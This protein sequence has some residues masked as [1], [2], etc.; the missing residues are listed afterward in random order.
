MTFSD[1]GLSIKN[2]ELDNFRNYEK[3][4]SGELS[5]FNIFIGKNGV[6]KTNIIESIQLLTSLES[7]RN[8]KWNEVI[9]WGQEEANVYSKFESDQRKLDVRLQI[10]NNKRKYFLNQ[11]PKKKQDLRGLLPAVLFSPDDMKLI[12]GYSDSRR[13]ALDSIG[14][15]ISGTYYDLKSEYQKAVKQK[16]KLLQSENP[17]LSMLDSWNENISILGS[18]FVKHRLSLFS[19][20]RKVFIKT[21][22][23][24]V[25]ENVIDVVYIPSWEVEH[26]IE[27][28]ESDY[29][30]EDIRK[31][32]SSKMESLKVAELSSGKTLSGP[33]RDEIRFYLDGFDAKKYAS[34]GQQRF[35][36]LS[37]K[38]SEMKT[39]QMICGQQPILLL[40]D[41]MSEL[42]R[43][44][45]DVLAE[46]LF[47]SAQTFITAT[48]IDSLDDRITSR[49][50]IFEIRRG[51]GP[52]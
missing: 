30:T 45:R 25:S 12:K 40:D 23:E 16:N 43:N 37:W 6:G 52:R 33:H 47:G 36:T 20:F 18:V 48:D 19:T 14:N 28:R 46:Y 35:I 22:S 15:Q 7:F 49:A 41:V 11:K 21:Y 31:L 9:R 32:L 39:I 38:I 10:K 17:S 4:D 24:M 5:D 34:Q 3:Y 13:D 8:P 50:R 42:D 44:K 26:D 27:I 1:M 29:E 2:I 51:N